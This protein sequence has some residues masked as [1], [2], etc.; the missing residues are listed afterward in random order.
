M[1]P[2]SADLQ[3]PKQTARGITFP[4]DDADNDGVAD[5]V[6]ADGAGET[7]VEHLLMGWV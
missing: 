7:K 2:S 6:N 1:S 3:N 4:K 5:K